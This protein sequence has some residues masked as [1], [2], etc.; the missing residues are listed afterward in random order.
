MN[1][2]SVLKVLLYGYI[3]VNVEGDGRDFEVGRY[4][5]MVNSRGKNKWR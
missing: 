2:E 4:K 3:W 1:L 5:E